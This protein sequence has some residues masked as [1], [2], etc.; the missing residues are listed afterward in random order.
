MFNKKDIFQ[1]EE[2]LKVLARVVSHLM[3]DGCVSKRYFAYYNK[4]QVLLENFKNDVKELFGEIHFISGKVNS[5]TSFY[6]IQN[7]EVLNFLKSLIEDYR[8]FSLHLPNFIK[9]KELKK[10]FLK[11]IF[12]DEGCVA[13]RVF[14]KTGEIKRNITL[15]AKSEFFLSQIKGILEKEFIIKCNRLIKYVKKVNNK[16]F[17]YWVLS[18]TGKDNFV[19]F[20]ENI[21]FY[22]PDKKNKLDLMISSYVKK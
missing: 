6:M 14:V 17:P 11:A 3:G 22:H 20:K 4:N 9:T 2:K 13:L 21:N 18:I 10:E 8:S 16:E 1:D 5:G 7:K 15:C 19:K 12:D